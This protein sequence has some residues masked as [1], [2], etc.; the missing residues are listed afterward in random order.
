VIYPR[1]RLHTGGGRFYA[2]PWAY[3][4]KIF[5]L[6][7]DGTTWVVED[8]PEFKVLHKN[9]LADN[10]WATPAISRGSLFM[11]TYTGL[12]RLQN[13]NASKQGE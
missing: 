6:N 1:Q 11:R 2:S 10:A 12:Y 7:E 9:I 4:G 5:L 3:N 8:G 13:K